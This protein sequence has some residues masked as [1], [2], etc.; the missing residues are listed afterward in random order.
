MPIMK[1]QNNR[2]CYTKASFPKEY[3][4]DTQTRTWHE[5]KDRQVIGRIITANP[6][7]GERYYL[8]MLLVHIPGPTSYAYLQTVDGLTYNSF[9]DAAVAHGLLKTDDSNEKCME[10]A[11]AYQMP[12][13]LR[14]LFCTILVYCAP[15]NPI[16]LFLKFED[17]MVED[18]VSIQ[19]LT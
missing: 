4:W 2:N 9:R 18:Y 17:Q 14:Q 19:Q 7:E 3:V 13:S 8:R 12:I 11:S 1:E 6:K 10:E 5:C 16:E 15:T